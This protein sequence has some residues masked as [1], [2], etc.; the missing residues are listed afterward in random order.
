VPESVIVLPTTLSLKNIQMR[1]C[2]STLATVGAL[3]CCTGQ[4][5]TSKF[6]LPIWTFHQRNTTTVGLNLG[7]ASTVPDSARHV[8]TIGIHAEAIGLGLFLFLAPRTLSAMSSEEFG[9]KEALPISER[10]HGLSV[11]P[12]G[13]VC[14]CT[15]NGIGLNGGGT[16]VRHVNGISLAIVIAESD[17]FRGLQGAGFNITYRGSGVQL[18]VMMNHA[19]QMHGV[20][21]AAYNDTK[22]LRGLQI[23]IYNRSEDLKGLQ[24]G[25]WNVNQKRKLPLFNWA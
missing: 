4:G 13:S 20:Q 11:S 18:G 9:S 2:L 24:I 1:A 22:V 5:T 6:R 10:V 16:F 8:T 3:A 14:D 21:I 25:L 23:G 7:V 12:L 17:R 15:L 19:F